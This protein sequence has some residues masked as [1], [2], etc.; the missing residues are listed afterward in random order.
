MTP[1]SITS[2]AAAL[3]DPTRLRLLVLLGDGSRPVGELA[4]ALGVTASVASFHVT[5]LAGVG[6]V[7]TVRQ[8]RRTVVRREHARWRLVISAFG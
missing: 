2:T 3:S 7:T 8:G 6:L 5:K 1:T 4:E